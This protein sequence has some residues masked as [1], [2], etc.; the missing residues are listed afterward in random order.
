[1]AH[2]IKLSNY[3]YNKHNEEIKA[4]STTKTNNSSLI[5]VSI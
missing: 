3:Y 4:D 1:M 5:A 2:E